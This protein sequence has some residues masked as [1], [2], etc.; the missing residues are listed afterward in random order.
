MNLSQPYV[1][2]SGVN[3]FNSAQRIRAFF[4][5][6]GFSSFAAAQGAIGLCMTADILMEKCIPSSRYIVPHALNSFYELPQDF[7]FICLHYTP[8]PFLSLEDQM[9]VIIKNIDM[10]KA[11]PI[12]QINN[13]IPSGFVLK[14]LKTLYPSIRFI[15]QIS[16]SKNLAGVSPYLFSALVDDSR[17]TGRR[18][19][20]NQQAASIM[21]IHRKFPSVGVGIAGGIN[22][23]NVLKTLNV[24]TEKLGKP[25][26]VSIDS[27]SGLRDAED[28]LR[29]EKVRH[30][31]S[32]ASRFY[33]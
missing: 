19:D 31:I 20:I 7:G 5:E 28:N 32:E 33:K 26:N 21:D 1:G 22:G 15:L 18:G 23:G 30:Y 9:A 29:I 12:I 6:N 14:N 11:A 3:D 8:D 13:F 4:L 17:G 2:I 27:E 16:D 10:R 25:L 24:L